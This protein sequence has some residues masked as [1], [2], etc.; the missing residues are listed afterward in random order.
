M[1]LVRVNISL[2]NTEGREALAELGA[3]DSPGRDAT[4]STDRTEG[5]MRVQMTVT[6]VKRDPLA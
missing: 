3:G 4:R 1:R 2:N 6:L 5:L